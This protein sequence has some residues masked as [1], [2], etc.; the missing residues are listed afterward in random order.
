MDKMIKI[1]KNCRGQISIFFATTILVII[2]FLA[3]VINVGV[4]VKAKM[5]LQ[6][7]V[8]AAAFAGAAVQARQL[9]NIAYL[10]WE[11]RNVYKEWMFKYYV[12]GNLNINDVAN[13][14]SGT[15]SFKMAT[16][17]TGTQSAED[18]YN[19]PS[20]CIDFAGANSTALCKNYIIPGLPRFSPLDVAGMGE[21]TNSIMDTLTDQKAKDCATRSE[22]NYA[23]TA[24]W[25]FSVNSTDQ[26]ALQAGAPEIASNRPGAFP[27]AFELAIRMRNL[28]A[29]VNLTPYTN[30]VCID[31]GNQANSSFCTQG[32]NDILQSNQ[33]AAN[34]RIN[35]AFFSGFRNLGSEGDSE[36]RNSFTLREIAPN[37]KIAD[38]AFSLSNLLIPASS[39]A[40][41]KYYLD[42]KLMTTNLAT[43]YT[44]FTTTKGDVNV[45]GISADTEGQCA[46]T[47]TGLPVPGYPMG[48]VK[49]PNVLTY[50]AV[51]GKAKFIGLFNPFDVGKDNG[52]TLTAYAAAKPF[53]GRIGP[54]I[55]DIKNET[56]VNP[57]AAT[58]TSKYTSSSF[59]SGLDSNF[60]VDQYGTPVA[61]GLYA[62]GAPLP[63]DLTGG[64]GF[65][66][67]NQSSSVGGWA[68]NEDAV[69]FGIPNIIYDYPNSSDDGSSKSYFANGP[70]Q[71]IKPSAN[72]DLKNGLY[73]ADIFNQF[74]N[75]LE[76]R[77]AGV[78]PQNIQD[79]IY[80][81]KAP[82]RWEANNYLIPTTETINAGLE[83]DSFGIIGKSVPPTPI[84]S[85]HTSYAFDIYAPLFSD[86]PLTLY[87]SPTEISGVLTVY[88]AAQKQAI[89]KYLQS[90]NTAAA[91]IFRNNN[92]G[93]TG[94]NLGRSSAEMVSDID[95]TFLSTGGN[96]VD[97]TALP[98]CISMAGKF[99]YFYFGPDAQGTYNLLRDTTGCSPG[100]GDPRD[101]YLTGMLE[102]YF[103][104]NS[105]SLGE[106]YKTTYTAHN[107]QSM[108]QKLFTAYR[109]GAQNDA[110]SN[111]GVV[112]NFLNSKPE[113]M[114]RNFYS[115]KFITLKSLM[116]S[117]DNFYSE[118]SHSFP[119]H[120]EGNSAKNGALETSQ[121]QYANS[122]NLQSI[123]GIDMGNIDH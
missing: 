117:G 27:T 66:Q 58:G 65:W 34:E 120:S 79:A 115:T 90:M 20:V 61:P 123:G 108:N 64:T 25:A 6:N 96:P 26:N 105:A 73:N 35:K 45:Q 101:S 71:V 52:I 51:E 80:K 74:A 83:V 36:M 13:Q 37:V 122:L 102:K 95:I 32:I 33:T 29:Q 16:Y 38:S 59:I 100:T 93:A 86:D 5:N 10:N 107:D 106:Y 88:L 69:V 103:A 85:D 19:F 54:M 91:S 78:T 62:P 112:K 118:I 43:F 21:T 15:T 97:P 98:T 8:D 7:A 110:S 57:R 49:N 11:M 39:P 9:T 12:L 77:G 60:F 63:I 14:A 41:N 119:I 4:F 109:P 50:Y 87:K 76:N 42:L 84:G 2:T 55:F 47:K 121:S 72:E 48:F 114:W 82:T 31:G 113:N 23:T 28:E 40:M 92:S 68:P 24:M 111:N 18:Q 53:G 70:I 81:T 1:I 104:D 67:K 99:I 46:A 116:S 22:L 94:K 17:A 30:G 89:T 44:M 56:T 75:L 3:F